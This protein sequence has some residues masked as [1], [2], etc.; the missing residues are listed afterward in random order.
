MKEIETLILIRD[1][2]LEL[3]VRVDG[4]EGRKSFTSQFIPLHRANYNVIDIALTDPTCVATK[5]NFS[6]RVCKATPS[7]VRIVRTANGEG[8]KFAPIG[9]P[10]FCL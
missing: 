10:F 9:Q 6:F 8:A 2:Y 7:T 4:V 1:F 3:H 5:S